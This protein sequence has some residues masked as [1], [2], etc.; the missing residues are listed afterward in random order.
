MAGS[1][2]KMIC[3]GNLGAA[4]ELKRFS[5]G[6]VQVSFSVATSDVW[7]D[8]Q[9]GE[10]KEAT[11][12]HRIVV[13]NEKL[14]EIAEKYLRKGSK[15]YL[16]GKLRTRKWTDQGGVERYV[17]EIEVGNFNGVLVLLDGKPGAGG[18]AA[19]GQAGPGSDLDDEVPW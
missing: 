15:V 4:P 19:G 11:E 7:R 2:N 8:K 18:I 3:L 14:A 9:T 13:R 6:G 5:S 1:V 12:W 10:R 17:T 16:E